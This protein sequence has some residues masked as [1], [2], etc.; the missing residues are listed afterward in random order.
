MTDTRM[1]KIEASLLI[2]H[3]IAL[4]SPCTRRKFGAIIVKDDCIIST[5]YNGSVRGSI[6]CGIDCPCLKDINNEESIKSYDHCPAVHAEMNAIINA[7]R[8]GVSVEG[9]TMFL[10][11]IF[12]TVTKRE[13]PCFLCRRFMIQAGI[14][15]IIY[16]GENMELVHEE[17]SEYLRMENQWMLEQQKVKE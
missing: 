14:K 9:G 2:A 17:I 10:D 4:R 13:R 8:R 1:S 12:G 3:D 16:Y 11:V 7:A 6:N 5:G 15:D